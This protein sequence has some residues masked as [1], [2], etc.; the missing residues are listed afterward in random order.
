MAN[1]KLPK[2]S[3]DEYAWGEDFIS[4]LG[5]RWSLHNKTKILEV[6]CGYGYWTRRY[7]K[8]L[9]TNASITL[10]DISPLY[11]AQA[12]KELKLSLIHI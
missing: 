12:K 6:G 3:V 2:K 7:L 4:L 11:L 5:K 9:P 10:S 8:E 1:M